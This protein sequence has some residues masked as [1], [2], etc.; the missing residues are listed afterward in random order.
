MHGP[1]EEGER[2]PEGSVVPDG[3]PPE[4]QKEI[5]REREGVVGS[6]KVEK[7]KVKSAPVSFDR[8]DNDKWSGGRGK[9]MLKQSSLD[10]EFMA[11]RER[12]QVRV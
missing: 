5:S 1:Q 10:V 9:K 3:D 4:G 8:E 12:L 6:K 11:D 2:R 7:E